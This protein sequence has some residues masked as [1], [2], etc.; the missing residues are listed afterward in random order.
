MFILD[1]TMTTQTAKEVMSIAECINVWS[2]ILSFLGVILVQLVIICT[3]KK[4]LENTKEQFAESN[5]NTIVQFEKSLANSKEQFERSLKENR[6]Q[7]EQRFDFDRRRLKTEMLATERLRWI[8]QVR[9]A[10]K[11]YK[12]C[13]RWWINES[14]ISPINQDKFAEKSAMATGASSYLRL[15]FNPDRKSV[16]DKLILES[17]KLIDGVTSLIADIDKDTVLETVIKCAELNAKLD[18]MVQGY[19]KSEYDRVKEEL[20]L[21]EQ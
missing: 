21:E 1:A 9:I 15:M 4:N 10:Y 17:I 14:L 8:E 19:L 6:E 16:N 13:I 5:R 12:E 20:E 2:M 11:D 3:F 7:F 18:K